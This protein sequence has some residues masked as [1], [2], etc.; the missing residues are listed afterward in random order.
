MEDESSLL[1][2]ARDYG[3]AILAS[4]VV[5]GVLFVSFRLPLDYSDGK[6]CHNETHLLLRQ[7]I[8]N[9]SLYMNLDNGDYVFAN[10]HEIKLEYQK[11]DTVLVNLCFFPQLNKTLVRG[12]KLYGR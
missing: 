12:V 9:D 10:E 4:F 8:Y 6:S 3:W 11:G 7:Y 2:F 1:I 5:I